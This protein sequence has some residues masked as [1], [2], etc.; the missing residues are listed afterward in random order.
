MELV[1]KKQP[2]SEAK[3]MEMAKGIPN[4]VE[5]AFKWMAQVVVGIGDERRSTFARQRQRLLV[6]RS[7]ARAA[8]VARKETNEFWTGRVREVKLV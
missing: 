1:P 4:D 8:Q 7:K 6:F 5:G 2:L 3:M